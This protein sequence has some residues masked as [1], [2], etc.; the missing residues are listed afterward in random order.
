LALEIEDKPGG[1]HGVASK[2]A[3]QN[4]NVQNASGFASRGRAVL[5]I[6]VDDLKQAQRVLEPSFRL[7]T[8]QEVLRL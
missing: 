3:A 2:L 6:E 1:L 5:L 7:L 4:I 8:A